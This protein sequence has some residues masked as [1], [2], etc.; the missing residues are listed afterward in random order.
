MSS[1]LCVRGSRFAHGTALSGLLA[2]L[3]GGC[4][5]VTQPEKM[6]EGDLQQK[7]AGIGIL[8][9]RKDQQNAAE[10]GCSEADRTEFIHHPNQKFVR[11]MTECSKSTWANEAKN[12]ECIQ[13]AMPS[14]SDDCANC[15]V[16]MAGCAK[17][18][19]KIPCLFDSASER[20]LECADSNCG[21]ALVR[22]SGVASADLP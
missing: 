11:Q 2:V 7:G 8:S 22:C 5:E 3:L 10:D 16:D 13:H 1:V 21:A 15:F 6:A 17:D 18:N 4:W 20:C 14:L 12:L 9:Q 19:C